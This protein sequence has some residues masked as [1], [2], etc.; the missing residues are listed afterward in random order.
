MDITKL[1]SD[2]KK[3]GEDLDE[4]NRIASE[5]LLTPEM[6]IYRH[7]LIGWLN[8]LFSQIYENIGV[9]L[10]SIPF[11]NGEGFLSVKADE[12]QGK[13]R[14]LK[15]LRNWESQKQTQNQSTICVSADRLDDARFEGMAAGYFILDELENKDPLTEEDYLLQQYNYEEDEVPVVTTENFFTDSD[16]ELEDCEVEDISPF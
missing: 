7:Q 6:E 2:L 13:T 12:E 3:L 11:P 14:L 10:T 15:N 8:S 16:I 9:Y 4:L 5:D 1:L